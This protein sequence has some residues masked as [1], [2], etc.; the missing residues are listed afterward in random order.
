MKEVKF[1]L[2][3]TCVYCF[4]LGERAFCWEHPVWLESIDVL[5]MIY[6]LKYQIKSLK[7]WNC[8]SLQRCFCLSVFGVLTTHCPTMR[9]EDNIPLLLALV[10]RL[11]PRFACFETL[12]RSTRVFLSWW[13]NILAV[14][15][16]GALWVPS[17]CALCFG[18]LYWQLRLRRPARLQHSLLPDPFRALIRAAVGSP[19][20]CLVLTLVG[21]RV[22]SLT[23]CFCLVAMT[24]ELVSWCLMTS[25][26][27]CSMPCFVASLSCAGRWANGWVRWLVLG[28]QPSFV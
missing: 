27:V 19:S 3:Q 6:L 25:G 9:D 18:L 23:V 14:G 12:P 15:T 28:G 17:D 7:S 5:W 21:R 16:G 4:L 13:C 1:F 20:S 24:S 11:V 26:L 22:D 8:G 2:K 10:G